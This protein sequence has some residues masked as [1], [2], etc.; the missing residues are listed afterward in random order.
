LLYWYKRAYTDTGGAVAGAQHGLAVVAIAPPPVFRLY[1]GSTKALFRL[2]SGSIKA[3]LR[4][5]YGFLKALLRL[6]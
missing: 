4:L 1:E 6:Y 2:Y 5:Y 3:L